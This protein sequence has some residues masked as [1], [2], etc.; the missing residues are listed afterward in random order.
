[1]ELVLEK[2]ICKFNGFSILIGDI[3]CKQL[4]LCIL[5]DCGGG[6]IPTVFYKQPENV[7]S[8]KQIQGTLVQNAIWSFF[9]HN[10]VLALMSLEF[11]L[12][13]NCLKYENL[14]PSTCLK[15]IFSPFNEINPR[16]LYLNEKH[17]ILM[18]EHDV[19]KQS[20]RHLSKLC[21]E[22]R[23]RII[24]TLVILKNMVSYFRFNIILHNYNLT[25]ARNYTF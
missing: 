23:Q 13:K 7:P 17:Y 6:D 3:P 15:C 14:V 18:N 22:S 19:S 2:L 1:M 21:I 11:A 24:I 4:P 25:F 12:C 20:P 10:A 8:R 16:S 5:L 9:K